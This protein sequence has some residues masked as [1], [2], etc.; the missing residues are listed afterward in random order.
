MTLLTDLLLLAVSFVVILAGAELF[1]NG[2]EWLGEKMGLG[3]GMVGSVLA[4]VG[5]AMPET[6]IPIIAIIFV[7]TAESEQ[8]GIGAILGAP[9][10][11]STAAMF[12]TGVAVLTYHRSGRRKNVLNINQVIVR[13]DL[14]FFLAMYIV[15]IGLGLPFF[16]KPYWMRL[17]AGLLLVGAYVLYVRQTASDPRAEGGGE[18]LAPLH[19]QRRLNTPKTRIVLL[20]VFVALA[21]II[22]GANLFVEQIEGIATIFGAPPL[23]LSLIVAPLATELPEKFNS[24]I[25]I[26]QRKDTLAMGNISGAMVFQSCIPVA[27]GLWFTPWVLNEFA[28]VSAVIAIAAGVL[29]QLYLRTGNTI[30]GAELTSLGVLYA[31][32]LL[33][34][35]AFPHT[36]VALGR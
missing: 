35:F 16:E 20:Q 15:A 4:A 22:F 27:V 6:M 36:A 7:G 14:R 30:S 23:V 25:W 21:A 8:V 3:E 26:R 28:I 17:V 34:V 19:F 11:L 5:T 9:F 31:L 10:L 32:F 24:V 12:V 2:I 33:Y 1:T 18:G 13:R 29:M